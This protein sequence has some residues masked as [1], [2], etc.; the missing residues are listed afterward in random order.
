MMTGS[1]KQNEPQLLELSGGLRLVHQLRRG[2]GAGI[3][4]VAVKAGSADERA[5]EFGL[6]HLVEHTIFKGTNHRSSWHII[7][8]MEAVGGELNAYT[9]KEET[10]IYS[11]FPSGKTSRAVELIADLAINSRFPEKELEKEREVVLDEINSYYDQ[12]AE[13]LY[14]DFEDRAFAGTPF[15]HNILGSPD[16]VRR[17][18][19]ADCRDFL[20]RYYT[21]DNLVL[22][23]SG[24]RS[25]DSV[26]RIC[27]RYFAGIRPECT[28]AD[29][30]F[31]CPEAP[32]FECFEHKPV[33][34][35]HVILG[36]GVGGIY[37]DE[38][39]AVALL[40]NMTGGP[41]MNSLLNVELRER[42]GLVY[43]VESSTAMFS[44]CGLLNVYF[45]CDADD[46]ER[47][48]ELCRKVFS[49]IA[50]GKLT[51]RK[52]EAAKKQYLGQLAIASENPENRIMN[53]ARAT[54]FKGHPGDPAKVVAAIENV[55][56]G[57]LAEIAARMLRASVLAFVP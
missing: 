52:L 29:R 47:C 45:G 2:A 37:S 21:A 26:A 10:V 49:D 41:G 33:H 42:R 55:A 4:G 22:F 46:M 7:N 57:Q 3:F 48:I 38:R 51:P 5:G 28:V 54:L 43:T 6:A 27:E 30:A 36:A 31:T 25:C 53:A 12:P 15:G 44:A 9:T 39:H 18:A 17:L 50:D 16:S 14:D 1:K 32:V 23:Y 40:A 11:I 24:S 19:G 34:Q 56:A 13:A 35:A 20:N 8:R